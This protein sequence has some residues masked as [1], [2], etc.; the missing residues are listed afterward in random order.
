MTKAG[1]DES[2]AGIKIAGRNIKNLRYADDTTLM[3]ESE[4]ELKSLLMQVKEKSAKVGLKLNIKKT[5]IMASSPLTLWQID[6]EQMEVVTDFIFLSSK[7]TADRDCSQ[8]IK[9]CLLLGRKAMANLDSILKSIDIT[10]PTKVRIVKAMVFP[11]A[12]YGCESWTI[13]KGERQRIEAFEMWCWRRLMRVPWTARRSNWSVLEEINPDCSLE[14]QILKMKLKYFGHL[15]RR[16]DSLEKSLMLGTIDGKRRRGR[17]RMRWL[18]GVTEAVGGS[19]LTVS[20]WQES[21]LE[22]CHTP[23]TKLA[24]ASTKDL[25]PILVRYNPYL[26]RS[27]LARKR[28]PWSRNPKHSFWHH[29]LSQS[30]TLEALLSLPGPNPQT[31][32]W[33]INVPNESSPTNRL[34]ETLNFSSHQL[35]PAWSRI[36]NSECDSLKFLK[37][38]GWDSTFLQLRLINQLRP[39]LEYDCLVTVTHTLVTSHLDFC[40]ALYVGLPLKTVRTLQLVQNRAARLLTGTGHY[41]HMTPVL[42]QLHWLPIEARAQFKVLVMTYKA[43]NGLGLGYLKERLRP[44]MPARPLR[45]AGEALLQ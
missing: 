35:Q 3:A 11:V 28:V 25:F 24:R 34:P 41:A 9:R 1:L 26:A 15:M 39:Y 10:L 29:T 13:R 21:T 31:E 12:M 4:E 38:P 42:R 2:P 36:V 16:K 45:S 5:K 27:P 14:G 22:T 23:V 20:Y 18:D 40:N 32:Q 33:S 43:L 6:G 19:F 17:Q 8:E 37:A 44:Y 30:F 7:I